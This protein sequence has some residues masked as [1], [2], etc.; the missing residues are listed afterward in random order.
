MAEVV[1]EIE[2][3][4]GPVGE[5]ASGIGRGSVICLV[6]SWGIGKAAL[7][8]S[9]LEKGLESGE[10]A[11]C[12]NPL[13]TE[14]SPCTILDERG[15]YQLEESDDFYHVEGGVSKENFGD[16]M[17]RLFSKIDGQARGVLFSWTDLH[18][19]MSDLSEVNMLARESVV[20]VK[21]REFTSLVSFDPVSNFDLEVTRAL[22]DLLLF[23]DGS[24]GSGSISVDG[25]GT[26]YDFVIDSGRPVFSEDSGVFTETLSSSNRRRVL[27]YLVEIYPD[28]AYQ[29]EISEAL[30]VDCVGVSGA[31]RGMDGRYSSKFSLVGNGLAEVEKDG[32]RVY[33]SATDRGAEVLSEYG[34]EDG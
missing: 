18:I 16:V 32:G 24:G 29:S 20:D 23:V 3:G 19:G 22:S 17:E 11:V 4:L 26:E 13:G 25:S 21:E 1:G 31:L 30:G 28:S 33:Y 9:F 6:G 12:V 14:P 2:L 15:N 10:G 7:A 27:E 34:S 8:S 5:D